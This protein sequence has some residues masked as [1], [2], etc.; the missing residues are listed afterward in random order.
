MS[1]CVVRMYRM[2]WLFGMFRHKPSGASWQPTASHGRVKRVVP[3]ANRGM[4]VDRHQPTLIN[5]LNNLNNSL[6]S[7]LSSD[8]YILNILNIRNTLEATLA[9]PHRNWLCRP[10]TA[11]LPVTGGERRSTP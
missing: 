1:V 2:F 11:T 4:L 8:T 9:V 10:C 5:I 7:L 6:P 3:I